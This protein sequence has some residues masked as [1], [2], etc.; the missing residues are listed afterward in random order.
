MDLHSGAT[1]T[2]I[3]SG[4]ANEVLQE[5]LFTVV[6]SLV[7][8]FFIH[9]YP[10][11]AG[12]LTEI[13]RDIIQKRLKVDSDATRSE[14]FTWANV[15][16]ALLDVKVYLY[17]L[18]F[19]ALSLPLYTL[20]L[21]LPSIIKA[22]GYTAAQA[23][24]LSVPPYAVAFIVTVGFAVWSERVGQRGPFIVAS[25]CIAVIGYIL[26]LSD[27]ESGV[28]YLGTILAAAGI[29]PAVALTLAWPANN[30]SGHTKRAVAGAMQ[31]SIGNLGAV[32]G[33][34]LY[35][36]ETAPRYYLGHGFALGYMVANIVVTVVTWFVLRRENTR[37]EEGYGSEK[38]DGISEAEEWLGDDDPRWRFYQ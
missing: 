6:V 13:E 4:I 7:S 23:Q 17:C 30:V 22:L 33:T 21:F 24:L 5:G 38:L 18:G 11:T 35:R 28:S 36:A 10:S 1:D 32:L 20:S 19:H 26:L 27:H 3:Y 9:N 37:R 34:Q 16:K 14:D 29:Y 25:S 8:Y 2:P 12:F 31:I 15:S